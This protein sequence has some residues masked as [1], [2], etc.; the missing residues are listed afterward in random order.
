MNSTNGTNSSS[1]GTETTPAPTPPPLSI[2]GPEPVFDGT[3]YQILDLQPNTTYSNVTIVEGV[4][5]SSETPL[6]IA[7]TTSVVVKCSTLRDPGQDSNFAVLSSSIEFEFAQGQTILTSPMEITMQ[8]A[9]LP[10]ASSASTPGGRRRL[11]QQTSMI[12]TTNRSNHATT[13]VIT[14]PPPPPA[15]PS[16]TNPIVLNVAQKCGRRIV[17]VFPPCALKTLFI[18]AC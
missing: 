9:P 6:G 16:S 12:T 2:V 10:C 4:R 14:T 13:S 1:N 18:S 7:E 8:A 17:R 5:I 11:L 15:Y 3:N